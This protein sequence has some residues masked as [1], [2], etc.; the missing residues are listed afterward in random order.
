ML[1]TDSQF[2]Y[3]KVPVAKG[4]TLTEGK[5][6]ET[7]EAAGMRAVCD[8]PSGCRY[9]NLAK[10]VVTPLSQCNQMWVALSKEV[11]AD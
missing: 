1:H 2:K 6:P 4:T 11:V 10:C 9:T 7:C 3:Y 5:V 8:G